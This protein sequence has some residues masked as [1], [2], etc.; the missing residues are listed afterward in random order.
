M[1]RA[2]TLLVLMAA[3][4]ATGAVAQAAPIYY[5]DQTAVSVI[6]RQVTE[7]SSTDATPL[8][9]EPSVSGDSLNF[10]PPS[11]GAN[12]SNGSIDLTDG[13]LITTIESKPGNNRSGIEEIRFSE[14]GDY[15][16]AGNG[17]ASTYTTVTC[18]LFVRITETT[19]GS[20]S[21]IVGT[22][23]MTF[24]PSD[25]SYYLPDDP[26]IGV[27]WQ[28]SVVVDV[29]AMLADAG[30]AGE[31]ALKVDLS[32]DNTLVAVSEAGTL[33]YIK[34]KQA[35]GITITTVVPEPTAMGLLL[36]GSLLL[37]RRR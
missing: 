15:T 34:K 23:Y 25:G 36:L 12:A 3:C 21:P 22:F 2:K 7:D 17:T 18:S 4:L 35:E 19:A 37:R 28:G 26:G 16:L 5:G 9:G 31:K 20:I 10:S 13:T 14:R 32:L 24:T 8:F 30:R 27:I 11:F 29:D 33:A 1:S 6:Y